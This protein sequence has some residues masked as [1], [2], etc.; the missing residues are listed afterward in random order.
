MRLF[1]SSPARSF[2]A[3]CASL[4]LQACVSGIDP[5]FTET[6]PREVA[7]GL[8]EP[9]AVFRQV[10]LTGRTF[11][12]SITTLAL[13]Q[14]WRTASETDLEAASLEMLKKTVLEMPGGGARVSEEQQLLALQIP[15]NT[16]PLI[17]STERRIADGQTRSTRCALHTAGA[18]LSQCEAMG[19]LAGKAP[20]SNQR[21]EA[22]GAHF[23]RWQGIVENRPAVLGCETTP[24]SPTLAY[25]G[26]VL[27]LTVDYTQRKGAVRSSQPRAD[28]STQ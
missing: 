7:A 20:D 24:Q 23:I 13:D 21:Y 17:L 28:A 9:V 1:Q 15:D 18:F 6:A 4:C 16:A 10:C 25:S 12:H 27:S 11:P 22:T 8:T 26:T 19:R 14:G 5:I 3:L 2:C